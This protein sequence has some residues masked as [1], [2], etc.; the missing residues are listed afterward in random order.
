MV[1]LVIAILLLLNLTTTIQVRIQLLK[2]LLASEILL[3]ESYPYL[4]LVVNWVIM[5]VSLQILTH[6]VTDRLIL[7]L[8]TQKAD[9]GNHRR[10]VLLHHLL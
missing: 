3:S 10:V 6:H 5:A 2:L 7:V 9:V 1:G 4:R 8:T